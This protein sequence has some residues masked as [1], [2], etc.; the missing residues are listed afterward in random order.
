MSKS[1]L[2]F[3][4][5]SA[6]CPQEPRNDVVQKCY[7]RSAHLELVGEVREWI[8]IRGE[9]VYGSRESAGGARP[10]ALVRP[11]GMRWRNWTKGV[12]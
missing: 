11:A 8:Q 1:L 4:V 2:C 6:Q 12:D 3:T 5:P 10:V 9:E 7:V